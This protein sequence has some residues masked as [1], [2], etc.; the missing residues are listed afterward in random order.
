MKFNISYEIK[1]VNGGSIYFNQTT[2]KPCGIDVTRRAESIPRNK[3]ENIVHLEFHYGIKYLL[4]I[5]Y[6][7]KYLLKKL[8][9][10]LNMS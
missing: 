4:E 2:L 10:K 5:K 6:E 8:N 9:M 1:Y 7:I 3:N